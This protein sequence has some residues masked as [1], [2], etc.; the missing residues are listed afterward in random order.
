MGPKIIAFLDP[1]SCLT[2]GIEY[3]RLLDMHNGF[4]EPWHK[5]HVEAMD[6]FL[7][8]TERGKPKRAEL[9]EAWKI[10]IEEQP[11]RYTIRVLIELTHKDYDVGWTGNSKVQQDQPRM[12]IIVRVKKEDLHLICEDWVCELIA[13]IVSE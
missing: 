3:Y 1:Y 10:M 9:S 2:F 5:C 6:P 12:D 13:F 8:F 7:F 4:A 11:L